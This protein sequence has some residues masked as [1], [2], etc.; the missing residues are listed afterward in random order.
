MPAKTDT[1]W[2]VALRMTLLPL[3]LGALQVPMRGAQA[4]VFAVNSPADI[5]DANPGDG[6]CETA[7]GNGVCTLRAAVMEA[8][9]LAGVDTINLQSNLTY[10]LTHS[11]GSTLTISD[12]VNIAG[13]GASSTIIDG[14]NTVLSA[15]IFFVQKCLGGGVTCDAQHPINVVHISGLTI[16]HGGLSSLGAGIENNATLL[17]DHCKL[18][19]NRTFKYGAAIYNQGSLTVTDSQIS[20]NDTGISPGGGGGIANRGSMTLINSTVSA[21]TAV[22]GGGIDTSGTLAVIN[23][24]VSGNH[25]S[26]DG[27]GIISGGVT[28]LYSSTVAFNQANADGTGS[29]VGGGVFNET[30]STLSFLNSIIAMNQS[31]AAG[32]FP[33]AVSDDCSGTITSQGNNILNY[34]DPGH[35]TVAGGVILADPMLGVLQDNGGPTFTHAVAAASP[36]IDAGNSGGCTD[37][38]GAILSTDQRGVHRPSGAYCD[39]GA[40]EST[41]TI[42]AND[43]EP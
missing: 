18:T 12:S 9:A 22:T 6:V 1:R 13:A 21:N 3:V 37:N 4:A 10:L 15:E 35:C 19:Q 17:V 31:I 36:A 41:E 42:F 30:N 20:E 26:G 5:V 43:F 24:T 11:P 14:N 32:P 2:K 28:G 7:P 39:I 23:S 34:A 38:F 29:G 27:G 25:S 16:Q 40:Y 8:N 33:L